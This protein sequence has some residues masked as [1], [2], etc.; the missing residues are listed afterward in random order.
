[1][2]TTADCTTALL[3]PTL[4]LAHRANTDAAGHW[5]ARLEALT[6]LRDAKIA[7][8]MSPAGAAD[9][10]IATLDS[11]LEAQVAR[12]A[13]LAQAR[14]RA[15]AKAEYHLAGG[16]ELRRV[17]A[18]VLVPSATSAGQVY[19]VEGGRCTCKAG[20]SGRPC[21][22]AAAAELAPAPSVEA[23]AARIA[24]LMVEARARVAA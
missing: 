16:L 10:A 18:A 5:A 17:G 8:G 9:L 14:E 2:A 19:R 11:E 12:D 21:W 6:A 23:K 1:M 13:K 24:A 22:H 20:E 3:D 7:E 15:R 4:P